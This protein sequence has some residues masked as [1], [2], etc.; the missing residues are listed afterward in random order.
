MNTDTRPQPTIGSMEA[1]ARRILRRRGI[2]P[3]GIAD[4]GDV[5][6]DIGVQRRTVS[7]LRQQ[8]KGKDGVRGL[9]LEPFPAPAKVVGGGAGNPVWMPRWR[10]LAWHLTRPQTDLPEET[11]DH[12]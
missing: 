6:A 11:T 8:Y 5:A 1:A 10:V 3:D 2:D 4:Q 9:H 12:A 7:W